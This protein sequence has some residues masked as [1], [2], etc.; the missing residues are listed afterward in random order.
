MNSLSGVVTPQLIYQLNGIVTKL[1][2]IEETMSEKPVNT[3]EK[4]NLTP[5]TK[6]ML[7]VRL[8]SLPEDMREAMIKDAE[9]MS[10]IGV[11]SEE[12]HKDF[13]Y[14]LLHAKRIAEDISGQ[15]NRRHNTDSRPQQS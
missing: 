14:V 13:M 8:P 3:R 5:Y 1:Y 12:D 11:N 2:L 4:P 10:A 7:G 15:K 6:G 9:A